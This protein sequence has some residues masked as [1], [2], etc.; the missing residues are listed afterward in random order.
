MLFMQFVI[1]D[2]RYLLEAKDIIEIVPYANLKRIPKAPPYV[3]GLLNYR[4]D[5]VPVIDICYLMGD[6]LCELKLSSRIA[7]VNY[8]NDTGES[9]CIGLLIEH[10]TETVR[11]NEDD[12][13]DSGVN[14]N[15]N[16]YLGKVIIDNDCIVQL[17]DIRKV[18]PEEAYGILFK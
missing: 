2:D 11:F 14:L 1:G 4:G 16:S 3:A 13:S 7:L 8:K 9:T 17:V 6:K 5:T 12:F 10:L 18:I 15:D